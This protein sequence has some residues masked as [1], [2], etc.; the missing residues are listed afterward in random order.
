MSP[1]QQTRNMTS[2]LIQLT[3]E[4]YLV[5]DLY[6]QGEAFGPTLEDLIWTHP[7]I[8]RMLQDHP[9]ITRPDRPN[10]GSRHKFPRRKKPKP[11][12]KPEFDGD[13]IQPKPEK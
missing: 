11:K 4:G 1:E 6:R 10:R 9:K 8:K 13:F 3:D 12:P 5:V 7:R 2:K